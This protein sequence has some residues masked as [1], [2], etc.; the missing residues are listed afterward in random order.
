MQIKSTLQTVK[1][2]LKLSNVTK[3][4]RKHTVCYITVLLLFHSL[5]Y[6]D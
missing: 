3:L 4:I 1:A 5:L 6:N 2:K